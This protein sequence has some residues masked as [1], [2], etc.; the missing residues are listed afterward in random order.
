MEKKFYGNYCRM[1]IIGVAVIVFVTAQSEELFD[2]QTMVQNDLVLETKQILIHEYPW[3]FNPSIIRWDNNLL[4]SF[5]VIPDPK[6]TFTSW[7]GVI[8]LNE[9]FEPKGK[10]QQLQ[11]RDPKSKV[12]SRAEDGR[13]VAIGDRLFLGYTDCEDVIITKAGCRMYV[14]ELKYDGKKF[15]PVNI[16]SFSSLEDELNLRNWIPY[17]MECLSSFEDNSKDRREK[18]WVPFDYYGK[19]LLAYSLAPHKILYPLLSTG[20]CE[21][22]A[23]TNSAISWNWGELRGGTS[24]LLDG[25][26]YLAFFHSAIKM[27]SVQTKGK[28]KLHYFMGAYTFKRDYPFTITHIS[29]QPIVG[30]DFYI[31]PEYKPYWNQVKV[32]FPGGFISDDQYIWVVYGKED[33]EMWV[34]KLD[35]KKLYQSLVPVS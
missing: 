18:N 4:M 27:K 22:F 5:R 23:V 12:P 15:C 3:A 19:L 34:A 29:P 1:L 6:Q 32:V 31:G 10:P 7:V 11:L 14:A 24:A 30:H 25:D 13:L 20:H 17:N 26:H 28:E 9:N 16:R 35:K 33:H 2:L 8:N 21:T